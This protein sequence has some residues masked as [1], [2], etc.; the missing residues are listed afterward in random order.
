MQWGTAP[1]TPNR[2][3]QCF[4]V[5]PRQ[6][7]SLVPIWAKRHLYDVMLD[8]ANRT[9][10]EFSFS[11]TLESWLQ[12]RQ[13]GGRFAP[14]ALVIQTTQAAAADQLLQTPD[15]TVHPRKELR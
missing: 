9:V 2:N 1:K 4:L 14:L 8:A 15:Y 5:I 6:C 7:T 11:H 13:Q 12:S 3:A 10:A